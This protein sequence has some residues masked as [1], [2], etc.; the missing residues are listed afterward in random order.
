MRTIETGCTVVDIVAW[1]DEIPWEGR[2]QTSSSIE[3]GFC[4]LVLSPDV[5]HDCGKA[6]TAYKRFANKIIKSGLIPPKVE[7]KNL[8]SKAS[9]NVFCILTTKESV[10]NSAC[11]IGKMYKVESGEGENRRI[12]A[13]LLRQDD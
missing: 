10:F 9:A 13:V 7:F 6:N 8:V 11:Q 3:R 12:C 1:P 4:K 5:F 2:Y